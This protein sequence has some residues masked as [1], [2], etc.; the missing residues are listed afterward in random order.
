MKTFEMHF[1]ELQ[2]AI[3]QKVYSA[4]EIDAIKASQS[5]MCYTA[6]ALQKIPLPVPNDILALYFM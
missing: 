5:C 3:P 1:A 2:V 6:H 4:V